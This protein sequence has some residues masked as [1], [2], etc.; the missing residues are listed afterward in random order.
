MK[1]KAT[2][3]VFNKFKANTNIKNNFTR[4]RSNYYHRNTFFIFIEFFFILNT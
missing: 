3:G 2:F 4:L 1:I